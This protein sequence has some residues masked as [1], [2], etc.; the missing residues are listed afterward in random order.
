MVTYDLAEHF[1][2]LNILK[3]EYA[4]KM[5]FT[6]KASMVSQENTVRKK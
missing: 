1:D 5:H 6:Q 2:A 3:P 4:K